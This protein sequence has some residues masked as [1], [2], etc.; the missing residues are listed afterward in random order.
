M[1]RQFIAM[2]WFI[3]YQWKVLV[4]QEAS[5]YKDWSRHNQWFG[6]VWGR[7]DPWEWHIEALLREIDE[8]VWKSDITL[9]RPFATSEWRVEKEDTRQIVAT[10]FLCHATTDAVLLWEDHWAYK[11]INPQDYKHEWVHEN[12]YTIFESYLTLEHTTWH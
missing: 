6:L 8:E 10:F 3:V 9:W 7:I 12:L 5:S 1:I 11:R 4:I 2:K